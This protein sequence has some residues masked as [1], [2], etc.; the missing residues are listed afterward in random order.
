MEEKGYC[1]KIHRCLCLMN[2]SEAIAV[3]TMIMLMIMLILMKT[4]GMISYC[5]CLMAAVEMYLFCSSKKWI[6]VR[7]MRRF[8]YMKCRREEMEGLM[9]KLTSCCIYQ[10]S[11]NTNL[12][13]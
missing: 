5:Y 8:E 12:G 11:Y 9:L 2:L 10:A 4:E 3:I 13:G 6:A 7:R 1:H